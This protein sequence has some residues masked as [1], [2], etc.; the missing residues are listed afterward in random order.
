MQ[1]IVFWT[2]V[3]TVGLLLLAYAGAEA[4]ARERRQRLSWRSDMTAPDQGNE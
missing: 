4:G 3:V 1:D 2:V